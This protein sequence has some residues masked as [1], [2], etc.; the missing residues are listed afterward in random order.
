M[1]SFFC[2][3]FCI[4]PILISSTKLDEFYSACA[5]TKYAF[6]VDYIDRFKLYL[7]E[8]PNKYNNTLNLVDFTR[9]MCR[10]MINDTNFIHAKIKYFVKIPTSPSYFSWKLTPY[11]ERL[12][13]QKKQSILDIEVKSIYHR[14]HIHQDDF[15]IHFNLS[16][17]TY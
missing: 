13:L 7:K 16:F 9:L 14:L 3:T 4:P 17:T 8:F 6:D 5:R 15:K 12:S 2:N 11:S 10:G 1:L